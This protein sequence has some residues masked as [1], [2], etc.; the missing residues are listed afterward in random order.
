MVD[1]KGGFR[2]TP[3]GET[4]DTSSL[5]YGSG[6]MAGKAGMRESN[7]LESIVCTRQ[8]IRDAGAEIGMGNMPVSP[9]AFKERSRK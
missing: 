5:K 7:K 6:L 9:D 2:P 4:T 8:S 3:G 1:K